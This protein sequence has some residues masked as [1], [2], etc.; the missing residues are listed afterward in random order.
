MKTAQPYSLAARIRSQLAGT[1][2]KVDSVEWRTTCDLHERYGIPDNGFDLVPP[3][4]MASRATL[5]AANPIGAGFL[6]D[7][8]VVGSYIQQ[9]LPQMNLGRLGAQAIAL[10]KTATLIPYGTTALQPTWLTD[11]LTATTATAPAFGSRTATRK[12]ILTSTTVSRQLLMQSNIDEILPRELSRAAAVAIDAA[13]IAGTGINGIPLGLMNIGTIPSASG[14]T[15]TYA[16]LVA[17]M[18]AVANANAVSDPASLGFLTSPAVA[19]LLKQR[20]FSDANLPIWVGSVPAG[21]IDKQ[22]AYSS[23]NVPA[24]SLIHGDFSNLLI[25]GWSDGLSITVDPFTGFQS[26]LTTVRLCVSVDFVLPNPVGFSTL[27]AIT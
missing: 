22:A 27:T 14:A 2:G 5:T 25:A 15:M 19:A 4:L 11:E 6:D 24:A 20:Y 12:T 16:M 21:E 23:T 17:L 13:G 1:W 10:D 8:T 26:G 3:T 7:P 18:E 9:L